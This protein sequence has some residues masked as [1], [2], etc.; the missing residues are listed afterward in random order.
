MHPSFWETSLANEYGLNEFLVKKI[1]GHSSRDLTKDVY[2]HVDT[3]RLIDE[4]NKI[5]VL[6]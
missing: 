4:I 3:Q 6:K 2:T 1:M 5:P